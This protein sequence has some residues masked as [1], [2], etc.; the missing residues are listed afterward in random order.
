MMMS[1]NSFCGP[2]S[3]AIMLSISLFTFSVSLHFFLSLFISSTFFFFFLPFPYTR[4][5]SESVFC[6]SFLYLF[7]CSIQNQNLST[8]VN[9]IINLTYLSNLFECFIT[10]AVLLTTTNPTTNLF[11]CFITYW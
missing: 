4:F 10:S 5:I 3:L 9:L 1:E 7:V 2:E 11:I 6:L 8:L